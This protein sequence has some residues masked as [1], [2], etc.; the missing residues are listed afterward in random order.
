VTVH[1]YNSSN[2]RFVLP[3]RS[4][5]YEN[6]IGGG[7]HNALDSY[8][9][10]H[11]FC[12]FWQL[13]KWKFQLLCGKYKTSWESWQ[14]IYM[15]IFAEDGVIILK[16][17]YGSHNDEGMTPW[18]LDI[19]LPGFWPRWESS[20]G[21]I[22]AQEQDLACTTRNRRTRPSRIRTCLGFIPTAFICS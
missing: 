5:N 12:P 6:W 1:A 15:H 16:V 10:K 7:V 11:L 20:K 17:C 13:I 8:F 4:P 14:C 22:K 9:T 3:T 19:G 18:V 21:M 2:S